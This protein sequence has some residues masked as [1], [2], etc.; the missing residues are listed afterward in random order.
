MSQANA[1][2]TP[3]APAVDRAALLFAPFQDWGPSGVS[4]YRGLCVQDGALT[5]DPDHERDWIEY[6]ITEFIAGLYEIERS[7]AAELCETIYRGR[8]PDRDFF[9]A[10]MNNQ[11][12]P[13]PEGWQTWANK[14]IYNPIRTPTY[15]LSTRS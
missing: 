11:E 14:S 3:S 5:Y 1:P 9:V 4:V 12:T 6:H 2:T 13:L 10:L 8:I 15:L 7:D